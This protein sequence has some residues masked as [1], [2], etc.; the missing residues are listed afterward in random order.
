MVRETKMVRDT[1]IVRDMHLHMEMVEREI[2][3]E[4]WRYRED[5]PCANRRCRPN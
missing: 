1:E 2:A 3:E 5:L 4:R